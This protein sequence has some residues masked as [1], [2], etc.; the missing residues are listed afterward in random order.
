M[1]DLFLGLSMLPNK[2]AQSIV[3]QLSHLNETSESSSVHKPKII[4]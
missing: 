1:S 4:E 2:W 3:E